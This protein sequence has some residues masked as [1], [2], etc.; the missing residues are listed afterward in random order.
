MGGIDLRLG[1][2]E[3]SKK[4]AYNWWSFLSKFTKKKVRWSSSLWGESD[5]GNEENKT[6]FLYKT[7]AKDHMMVAVESEI[8]EEKKCN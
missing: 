2:A 8:K 7:A 3:S 6:K 5:G 1:G 4:F